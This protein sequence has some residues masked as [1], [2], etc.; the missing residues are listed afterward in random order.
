MTT[1]FESFCEQNQVQYLGL[2]Q[3]VF[4]LIK[5]AWRSTHVAIVNRTR[6]QFEVCCVHIKFNTLHSFKSFSELNDE[7]SVLSV[8]NAHFGEGEM[9]AID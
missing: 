5:H 1:S 4:M 8:L 6:K 2:S 7:S 9:M 3:H